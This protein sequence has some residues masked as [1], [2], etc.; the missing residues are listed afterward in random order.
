[1]CHDVI[2]GNVS[3]DNRNNINDNCCDRVICYFC[4]KETTINCIND[5]ISTEVNNQV[6]YKS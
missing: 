1:M 2:S 6:K 4:F 5:N 3:N